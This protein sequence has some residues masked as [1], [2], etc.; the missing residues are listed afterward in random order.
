MTTT[1]SRRRLLAALPLGLAMPLARASARAR[2]QRYTVQAL[3][4]G[5]ESSARIAAMA[6]D[7]VAG[8]SFPLDGDSEAGLTAMLWDQ[9][10]FHFRRPFGNLNNGIWGVNTCGTSVGHCGLPDVQGLHAVSI[11]LDGPAEVLLPRDIDTQFSIAVGINDAGVAVGHYVPRNDWRHLGFRWACGVHQLLPA[12]SPDCVNTPKGINVEGTIAGSLYFT[13]DNQSI[14][15]A[16]VCRGDELTLLPRDPGYR[17]FAAAINDRGWVVG[18][19]YPDSGTDQAPLL[20]RPRAG[21]AYEHR[22]LPKPPGAHGAI[23]NA[24]GADGT[25]V[26]RA[27]YRWN[28]DPALER[29]W[30]WHRGELLVLDDVVGA[31][32][33]GWHVTDAN[34]I[35]A[36]G[37]IGVKLG[38]YKPDGRSLFTP[39]VLHPIAP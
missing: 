1:F 27:I 11:P 14:F 32:P 23:P 21:G 9:R 17:A 4:L 34:A 33:Q 24:I 5:E 31:L 19:Q 25:V 7:F 22:R 3:P 8:N 28:T 26:G 30:L 2:D 20:W 29:A 35:D 16:Y 37:R 15:H 38:R 13:V 10:H 39:A 18:H 12:P 36:K 6:G